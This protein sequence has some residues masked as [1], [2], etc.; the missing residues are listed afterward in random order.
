LADRT[1]APPK[2]LGSAAPGIFGRH[3][4]VAQLVL[5]Q[6]AEGFALA[7]ALG[8]RLQRR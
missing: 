1:L 5:A 7:L 3:S 6:A 4:N 8:H 2:W